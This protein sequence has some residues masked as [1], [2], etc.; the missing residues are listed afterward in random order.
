MITKMLNFARLRSPFIL[1]SLIV[2]LT[3]V[4]GSTRLSQAQVSTNAIAYRGS[5][6]H[7]LDDPA[8]S[9]NAYQYIED[10]LL[11]IENGKVKEV[12]ETSQLIA[13]YTPKQIVDYRGKIIM[14][15]FVDTH[16]HYPQTEM[17]AS[18]GAQL[19]EWLNTYTFPT[20]KQF[21][22]KKYAQNVA[23]FFLDR[24]LESGTTTALVFGTVHKASIDALFE[25]ASDRN[26]RLIAG[27]VMMDRNAP[28]YLLDTPQTS[29]QDSKELIDRWHK[30]ER[31]LYAVTPRFAPTST[32]EQL[33]MAGKL[34]EEYPDVYMHTH[35]SENQGEVEWVKTLFPQSNSYLGVYNDFKLSRERSIYAHS[36]H[37]RDEDFASLAKTGSGIA[38]CPTSNLFLGSGL[39][40]LKRAQKH[41]VRVGMGTDVGGGTS[42]SMLQ[43]MNEAY[44]VIQ[45]HKAFSNNP[46]EEKP[47][48]PFE[49]YY[50]ST[51]GGAKALYL[52]DKI[53]NFLPGKEADFIVLNP[54]STDLL[55]F[56]MSK[57]KTLDEKLFVLQMLGDDRTVEHTY[58][59]GKLWEKSQ[60]IAN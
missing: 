43:T 14:P 9:Q 44:K 51:L 1:G 28:D 3:V 36:I 35:L 12:G 31:L 5:I 21:A 42:F 59:M 39:F 55:S 41:D 22:D 58:I 6:F 7:L 18:Y 23:E 40:D 53:G 20:E 57:T 48:S 8:K 24:L 50:L 52:D 27:K 17:I 19:L 10:G 2:V 45:M 29:Y 46:K 30:K 25:V 13:R 15:G 54:K 47:L 56:R 26:L 32:P 4:L 49:A 16:I 34:L 60:A 38:F 11:A 37:L 33:K